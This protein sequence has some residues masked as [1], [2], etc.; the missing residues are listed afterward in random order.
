MSAATARAGT[1]VT[2]FVARLQWPDGLLSIY[3]IVIAR[4]YMWPLEGQTCAWMI[5]TALGLTIL[6]VHVSLREPQSDPAG[7]TFWLIVGLP[8][9]ALFALRLPFPDKN[10]DQLDY[11]LFNSTRALEGWP[12]TPGDFFPV[13]MQV[14]PA[15][16]MIAGIFR[17]LLGY[18][19]GTVVNLL[20]VLW[21][22]VSIE[23]LLRDHIASEWARS[24]GALFAVSTE[25]LLFLLNLYMIDLLGLPLL[26]EALRLALNLQNAKDKPYTVVQILFFLGLAVAFKLPNLA[27]VFPVIALV[28][29]ELRKCYRLIGYRQLGFAVIAFSIPLLPFSA[30]MYFQ[31]GN[32]IFPFYNQLFRSPYFP[33]QAYRDSAMGPKG[34]V[35][36]LTWP[37]LGL[38]KIRRLTAMSPGHIYLGKITVAYLLA[39]SSC[40]IRG[41]DTQIRV[42]SFCTT[43][44]IL[45]WSLG[46]G[47]IRYAIPMEVTGGILTVCLGA[48][49]LRQDARFRQFRLSVSIGLVGLL[50]LQTCLVFRQAIKHEEYY[51]T[52]QNLDEVSQPTA[53]THLALYLTEAREL[54]RDRDPSAFMDAETAEA[55]GEIEVWVNSFD[56]TSGAEVAAR[57]DIPMIS[58]GRRTTGL[59]DYMESIASRDL[60]HTALWHHRNERMF[61]LVQ[62]PYYADALSTIERSGLRVENTKLI[63]IPFYSVNR[64]LK[65]L[66]MRVTTRD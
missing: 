43:A 5:S 33:L 60:L 58:L 14:N 20:A 45:F 15:P 66:L 4:Q 25:H 24:F 55:L 34:L 54:F 16:D 56:A 28:V 49:L 52:E 40:F 11:H 47:D 41:L 31:T 64:K 35:E 9:A 26:I 17:I 22:A 57:P 63:E 59:F 10:W 38:V 18:R 32:P 7:P 62:L 13:V 8:L 19:L 44:M 23:R 6:A 1:R 37:V 29:F 48:I 42:L 50:T 61:T 30:F 53:Y 21:T 65:F 2:Q 39:L 3:I 27:F 36:I 12:F 46:T 51:S